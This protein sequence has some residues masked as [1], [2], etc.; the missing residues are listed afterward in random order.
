MEVIVIVLNLGVTDI[1][2][3][4]Q[5]VLRFYETSTPIEVWKCVTFALFE[6]YDRKTGPPNDRSTNIPTD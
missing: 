4:T 6:N 2:D 3:L 5:F 1:A